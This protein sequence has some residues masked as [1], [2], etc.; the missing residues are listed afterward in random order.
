MFRTS[1][2]TNYAYL[3]LLTH[4]IHSPNGAGKSTSINMITGELKPTCGSIEVNGSE[5]CGP[6]AAFFQ[7][8]CIG[9]CLQS[10]ALVDY[11]TPRDHIKIL[12]MIRTDSSD[13]QI[14]M[15]TVEA[16][17]NID[18]EKYADRESGKLSGGTRRKLSVALAML[19]GSRVIIL[20]E[21]STGMDPVTR[22]SLWNAI[23]REY[24]KEGRTVLLT[25]HSMEEAESVC[26]NIGIISE[27]LLRCYG[28][29]QHLKSVYSDGYHAI[30]E[31]KDRVDPQACDEFISS[32][33]TNGAGK[34][35]DVTGRKRTYTIGKVISLGNLFERIENEKERLGIDTYMVSQTSLED[36]FLTLIRG[37]N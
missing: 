18:L 37:A 3:F 14:A 20:D 28:T 8:A 23:H 16:L 34:L 4:F 21:P 17:Q 26:S 24:S 35:L 6:K 27:G 9:R 25:T 13:E 33:C 10:D 30:I 12:S 1:R 22:R 15:D 11:L 19:P 29:V 7:H 32:I 5:L 31:L 2:V 36:V